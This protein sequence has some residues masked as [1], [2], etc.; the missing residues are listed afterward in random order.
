MFEI[1]S[2]YQVFYTFLK[3]VSEIG[4][5]NGGHLCI[6]CLYSGGRSQVEAVIY[7]LKNKINVLS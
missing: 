6:L 1:T 7:K 3:M 4:Y 2:K 5:G